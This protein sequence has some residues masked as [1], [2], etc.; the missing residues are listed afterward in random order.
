MSP[1]K[2]QV[3]ISSY[4][5]LFAN[6]HE[7][8]CYDGWFNIINTLCANIQRVIDREGIPQI[9]ITQIKE[10]FGTLRYYVDDASNIT[11]C[12]LIDFAEDLSGSTCEFCG[13]P[14]KAHKLGSWFCTLCDECCVAKDRKQESGLAWWAER[15]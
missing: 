8:G 11:I 4:P 12:S 5:R 10:K 15:T 14:G 13:K 9:T 3:L 7:T 2:T 1:E 6:I